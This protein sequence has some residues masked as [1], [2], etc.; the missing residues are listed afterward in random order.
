MK[1]KIVIGF[2]GKISSGK[3]LAAAY[4]AKKHQA[5]L[6]MFSNSMRNILSSLSLP[7]H[8]KNLQK[9]SLILRQAFGQDIFSKAV[10]KEIIETKGKLFVIDGVR[11]WPDV[12]ILVKQFNFFLVYIESDAKLR[13]R[14]MLSRNQNQ[15]DATV[16]WLK[17]LK[18]D[19]AETEATISAL[20]KPAD[21]IITNNTTSADFFASL[22]QIMLTI[23][24]RSK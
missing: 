23:K 14:R 17:F 2:T 7:I 5:T 4:L 3:G 10:A 18:L 21:F 15:N 6:I 19:N 1:K 8:R 11:R 16:S 13:W 9:L 22:D 20:K 12:A 24:K